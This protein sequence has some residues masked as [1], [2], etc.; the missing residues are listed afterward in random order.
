[1]QIRRQVITH[2]T[3]LMAFESKAFPTANVAVMSAVLGKT[4]EYHV[5][6]NWSLPCPTHDQCANTEMKKNQ[7]ASLSG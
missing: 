7:I 1:M 6:A 3:I 5:M 2:P 4:N